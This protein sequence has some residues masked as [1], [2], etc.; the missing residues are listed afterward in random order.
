[1]QDTHKDFSVDHFNQVWG[2]I[3]NADRSADDADNMLALAHSS[4]WH[5]KQRDDC[6]PMNLSIGYW[7]VSRVYTLFSNAEMALRFANSCL[8]ISLENTIP[9][10]GIGYAYEAVARANLL[11][12]N[13]DSVNSAIENAHQQVADITDNDDKASLQKDL[14][15]ISTRAAQS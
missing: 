12:G 6:T 9:P 14:D 5:W 10:F 7:Q 8:K 13:L 15:E 2:I 1:M 11:S 4:L 3:D